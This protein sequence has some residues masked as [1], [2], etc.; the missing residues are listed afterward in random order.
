MF[1]QYNEYAERT[2][3]PGTLAYL[4]RTKDARILMDSDAMHEY[5]PPPTRRRHDD[6]DGSPY[7]I[8]SK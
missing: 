8:A 2:I 3:L 4:I 7:G 5:E 6:I 1:D